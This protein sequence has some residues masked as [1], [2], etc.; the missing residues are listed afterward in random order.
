MAQIQPVLSQNLSEFLQCSCSNFGLFTNWPRWR[1][2]IHRQ[3]WVFVRHALCQLQNLKRVWWELVEPRFSF[4]N[5]FNCGDER[6]RIYLTQTCHVNK[7]WSLAVKASKRSTVNSSEN[8]VH[9]QNYFLM[10]FAKTRYR[11]RIRC[12]R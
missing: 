5:F 11:F 7:I 3:I 1:K 2:I 8:F 6:V 10:P 9:S 4:N 12:W